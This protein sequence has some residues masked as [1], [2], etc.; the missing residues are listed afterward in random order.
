MLSLL[1]RRSIC[2]A[3]ALV[4]IDAAPCEAQGYT[5]GGSRPSQN[6]KIKLHAELATSDGKQVVALPKLGLAA[7]ASP[8]LELGIDAQLRH[9]DHRDSERVSGVGDVELKAKYLLLDGRKNGARIDMSAELKISLPLGDAA[10]GLGDGQPAVKLPIT[11]SRR[12]GPWEFGGLVGAQFV[13]QRDKTM[14]LAGALVTRTLNDEIKIGA[15]I[16]TEM[17]YKDPGS[18]EIMANFGFRYQPNPQ[19]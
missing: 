15:E 1:S 18:Q 16:A 9:I 11:F 7:P 14:L 6:Q 17:R 2:T 3:A 19:A 10:R 13:R 12:S 4:G 5:V 8:S